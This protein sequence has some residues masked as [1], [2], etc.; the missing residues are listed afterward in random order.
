MAMFK[1][2]EPFFEESLSP[3]DMQS[4]SRTK[5]ELICNILIKTL[6]YPNTI[7]KINTNLGSLYF[8]QIKP[9]ILRL[10]HKLV[11]VVVNQMNLARFAMKEVSNP[12]E[13]TEESVSF[14]PDSSILKMILNSFFSFLSFESNNNSKEKKKESTKIHKTLEFEDFVRNNV[15]SN[16]MLQEESEFELTSFVW[17]DSKVKSSKVKILDFEDLDCDFSCDFAAKNESD[18]PGK[19]RM[20]KEKN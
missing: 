9:Q 20:F 18:K 13:S 16:N 1:Y 11:F 10:V 6:I 5:I 7:Q 14:S 3:Y 8:E 15:S 2:I 17:S 19:K 4:E 12:Y